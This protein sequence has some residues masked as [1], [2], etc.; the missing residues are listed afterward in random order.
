MVARSRRGDHHRDGPRPARAGPGLR[1]DGRPH[2]ARIGR[3]RPRR[4]AGRQLRADPAGRGGARG[5]DARARPDEPSGA[6]WPSTPARCT[7]RTWPTS[8]HLLVVTGASRSTWTTR[9]SARRSSPATERSCTL[10]PE[11]AR[12]RRPPTAVGVTVNDKLDDR[13]VHLR[14]GGVPGLR[15]DPAG[16]EAAA[17]A[18][19]VAHQRHLG[20]RARRVAGAGRRR[21]AARWPP[22]SGPSP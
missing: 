21:T 12:A 8:P 4:R 17:H 10:D 15:G 18:A 11:R 16:A 13:P 19:D 7:R 9:S 20:D 2:G 5:Q 22:S 1:R 6:R 3:G 14:P